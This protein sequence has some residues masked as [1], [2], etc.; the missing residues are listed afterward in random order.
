MSIRLRLTLLYTSILACALIGFSLLSYTTVA[1]N[2]LEVLTTTLSS[3][4]RR[5]AAAPNLLLSDIDALAFQYAGP[6]IYVQSRTAQGEVAD[7]TTNLGER[8][9]PFALAT[10]GDQAIGPSW[11]TIAEVNGERLLIYNQPLVQNGRLAGFL[12]LAASLTERERALAQLRRFLGAGNALIIG[13]AFAIGWLLASVG[14][15]PI[16]RITETAQ[17][18]GASRDFSRRVQPMQG[19]AQFLG[20]DEVGQL[21]ITFNAMLAELQSAHLQTEE[22]LAAQRRFV[23]D[24]SH[25]L[26]TPLTTIRG[27]LGLLQ[28]SPPIAEAERRSVLHDLVAET[29]RLIRLVNQLFTLARTDAGRVLPCEPVSIKAVIGEVY[30]QI[31]LLAPERVITCETVD[32]VIAWGERDA[33][34]QVLLILL[35]NA[36]KHTPSPAQIAINAKAE[37]NQVVITVH[38]EGDGIPADKLPYLFERFYQVE[39]AR[40]K[41]GSGLGLAIAKALTE[42]QHG[43]L[44]VTSQ[45][46]AGSTFQ[47]TLPRFQM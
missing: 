17:S 3:K 35:D 39:A 29:E 2:G 36:I 22:A 41:A 40:N 32:E 44:T 25:E 18:I 11:S 5:I 34:K 12:Q 16:Q 24:A 19:K 28:R 23:A 27:N 1:R 33:L 13:V 14:L 20:Q 43:T 4:M 10:I 6:E 30:R 7:R 45:P 31:Q 26:R 21:A 9:L 46:Y 38:D 8:V 15:R 47:V 42:A 37:P